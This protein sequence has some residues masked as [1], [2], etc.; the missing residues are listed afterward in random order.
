MT[1]DWLRVLNPNVVRGRFRHALFD[2]DGTISVIR[3][4]W[5]GIMGP[6]MV[7][8]ICDGHEP[9]PEIEAEVQEYIDRSTG[10]LTIEQMRWLEEAVRRHGLAKRVRTARAYKRIYIERLSVPVRERL[11]RL[12]QGE[13]TQDGLMMAGA[14]RFVEGLH[15]RG[16]T[17][18]VASGTDHK[19]VV[20][21]VEALGMAH[22]FNGGMYGSRDSG[23][24]WT[25]DRVIARILADHDLHGLELLV[26]GDGPVEIRQAK[27]QGAVAL[28]V[29]TDEVNR[30]G[31]NERKIARLT[32]AGADLLAPD[33]SRYDALLGFLF[34]A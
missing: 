34:P 20:Q 3:Q 1:G 5:E 23:E 26:V 10:I 17:L 28:G 14:R 31:W 15:A 18:Y 33:F 8:V 2:F 11:G 13:V 22:F 6:L 32:N 9:A 16:L 30:S 24:A 7:E 19:F 27:A 12:E 25:K 29:A 4:G 21:E